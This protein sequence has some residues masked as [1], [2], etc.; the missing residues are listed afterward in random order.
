MLKLANRGDFQQSPELKLV[1][2]SRRTGLPAPGHLPTFRH[3]LPR[4]RY[5]ERLAWSLVLH[6]VVLLVVVKLAP[7]FPAP[8]VMRTQT[9]SATPLY[10]PKLQAPPAIMVPKT[11]A[12]LLRELAKLPPPKLEA[13]PKPVETAKIPKPAVAAPEPKKKVVPEISTA[14]PAA[15]PEPPK[16]EIITNAFTS[17]SSLLPTEHKPSREVQTG[18]FGDPNGVPGTSGAKRT[19]TI[20]SVG[21]FDLPSGAGKG[22]G[23]ASTHGTPGTVTSAGFGDGVA[24]AGTGDHSRG[25]VTS[26]GFSNMEAPAPKA[27][28]EN[29]PESTPVEILYKPKPVYSTEARQLRIQGEVLVE[30]MF[31]ASGNLEVNR[32]TRGLGHGLDEAALHAA[33]LIKFRPAMRDGRPY[34]SN[35]VVHI[36]FELAE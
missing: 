27:R 19:A 3:E 8:K 24:A 18:G 16:K 17:G 7:W 15:K 25:T 35:A 22:N 34:D 5:K 33:E 20:A 9:A 13:P 4:W 12:P 1:S 32:V 21:S 10:L 28:P 14:V 31:H 29:K 30:V 23:S 26:A 36:V 2:P 6:A 11:K